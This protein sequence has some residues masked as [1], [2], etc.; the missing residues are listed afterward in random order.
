MLNGEVDNKVLHVKTD[1]RWRLRGHLHATT[2]RTSSL[3]R[4]ETQP[5]SLQAVT[6]VTQLP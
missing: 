4:N 1:T 6:V 5:L 2:V 3:A